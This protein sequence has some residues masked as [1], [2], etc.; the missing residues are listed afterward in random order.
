MDSS[1]RRYTLNSHIVPYKGR[2]EVFF[3]SAD[4]YMFHCAVKGYAGAFLNT[5]GG[6]IHFGVK[7]TGRVM[8]VSCTRSQEDS[9]RLEVD[10]VMK[11]FQPK[12]SPSLYRLDFIPI[13]SP[14]FT[15]DWKVISLHV[16]AGPDIMYMDGS[17]RVMTMS[18]K[19][20]YGPLH[21]QEIQR[22]AI[23][24]YKQDVLNADNLI[25]VI[26]PCP[27]DGRHKKKT[28]KKKDD[29]RSMSTQTTPRTQPPPVVSSS[30]VLSTQTTPGL[31]NN[32]HVRCMNDTPT[33]SST[34]SQ[35][36]EP[37]GNCNEKSIP[38]LSS[39][40]DSVIVL[41]LDNSVI[42]IRD[43]DSDSNVIVLD[44]TCDAT[45]VR[46]PSDLF[47]SPD[48]STIKKRPQ[49]RPDPES[50]SRFTARPTSRTIGPSHCRVD[51]TNKHA[52]TSSD[53]VVSH[54]RKKLRKS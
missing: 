22:L 29:K 10:D 11:F 43:S 4:S 1:T 20:L 12:V 15:F 28:K 37:V 7:K 46:T 21:P 17:G 6:V 54:S 2:T 48:C 50:P 16:S 13:V 26:T 30:Q 49:E 53:T 9:Y 19:G 23:H 8:G 40:E 33:V 31:V 52:R 25:K 51:A 32:T 35:T 3:E 27:K 14:Q 44:Q 41:D 18:S 39:D 24:K 36:Q 42:T 47:A 45:P 5:C 34:T 38:M